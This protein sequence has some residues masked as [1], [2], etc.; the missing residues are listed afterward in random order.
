[1]KR[2][3]LILFLFLLVPSYSHGAE[4]LDVLKDSVDRVLVILGDPKYSDPSTRD[5]QKNMLWD[6]IRQ[7]FDFNEMARST[8]ARH[9]REFTDTQK[10]EFTN[11]F[12]QFLGSN[13]LDKISTGFEGEKVAY[14]G[15]N[16]TTDNK[17]IVKTKILMKDADAPVDY[18]MININGTWKVYDVKVEG[19]SLIKNY[20][21]QFD[22][23][24]AKNSPDSL[25]EMIRKKV[26]EQE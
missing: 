16:M 5:E 13:Y 25:I 23:I 10:K 19:I 8:I 26:A 11:V 7:I 20:R 2:T 18:S 21:S 6:I 14:L 9:W 15:Y 12:G 17:A 24:L 22:S 3:V 4:P 1:M